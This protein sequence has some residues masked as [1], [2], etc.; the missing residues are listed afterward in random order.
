LSTDI[1]NKDVVYFKMEIIIAVS[2]GGGFSIFKK[3]MDEYN[4]RT[5][6]TLTHFDEKCRFLPEFIERVKNGEKISV[7]DLAIDVIPLDAFKYNAWEIYD[8]DGVE[9]I[10]ID[11]HKIKM[12]KMNQFIDMLK[13]IIYDDTELPD[14]KRLEYIRMLAP[15]E[16]L[17]NKDYDM[18]LTNSQ[19]L[20]I[21]SSQ[22]KKAEL[23]FYDKCK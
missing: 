10:I 21:F 7:E 16:A 9:S 2:Y 23:N 4:A 20:P 1:E 14:E 8:Y 12:L 6:N 22:F 17:E 5:Q 13:N 19:F 3:V 15:R 18:L 11:Y